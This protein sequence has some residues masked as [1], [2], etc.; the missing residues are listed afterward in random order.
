MEFIP[1]PVGSNIGVNIEEFKGILNYQGAEQ[2]L[3]S[4]LPP[5]CLPQGT[6][7]FTGRVPELKRL[8]EL[9]LQAGQQRT[10]AIVGVTGQGGIGKSALAFHFAE[11]YKASF[12]D[13]I[14]GERVNG[15]D[16]DTIVRTFARLADVEIPDD[17]ARPGAAVLMRK[18]FAHR[19]MLLI[20]DNAERTADIRNLHPGGKCAVIITTR[21]RSLPGWADVPDEQCIDLPFLSD[22]EAKD[23]LASF[24]GHASLDAE[25]EAVTRILELVGN[26]PLALEIVGKSLQHWRRR[27]PSFRLAEYAENLNL[28][29]L[30]AR[31]DDP[32]L[33]VRICFEQSIKL[34]SEYGQTAFARLSA[35]AQGGFA[36]RTAMAAMGITDEFAAEEQLFQLVDLSLLNQVQT[37][38]SRFIFH[39]LL[40][41]FAGELAKERGELDS[42]RERHAAH[43]A[44]LLAQETGDKLAADL[45]DLVRAAEWTAERGQGNWASFSFK[46]KLVFDRLGRWEEGERT[47]ALFLRRAEQ[48]RDAE[49]AAQLYLQ[50]AKFRL[51]KGDL[52]QA[53]ACLRAAD[54]LIQTVEPQETREHLNAM[55]L[56][57]LGGVYQRL[58]RFEEA[59]AAFTKSAEIEEKSGSERGQAMILNS[60]GGVF[61]RLGR[62]EE[63]VAAFTKSA[64]IGEKLNDHR[65]LAMVLNSLG[66]VFQRL[67]RFEEAV[68]AFT[69]SAEIGE[70]LG[71]QRHLAMVLNSLGGVYQRL[72]RF[73]EAV[74]AFTKSLEIREAQNDQQGLAMVLN[75]L[76][77]VYQ[78]LGRFE[79][80]VA[81][82]TKSAEIGETLHDQRHLAMV[83][84]S[85]GGVY[86]RL[87]RFEEAVAAFTKSAEIGK[88]LHDQ[89]HLAMVLNSL[90]G[91]YQ[92]LG[93]F[94]EAVAAFTKSAE[95]G[96]TLGDQRHLAMVLNSLGGVFQRLGQFDKAVA[97]FTKSYELAFFFDDKRGQAMISFS[98]GRA[99]LE[100]NQPEQAVLL[101]E[102][103]F[104]FD[105][106][107]KDRVGLAIVTPLLCQALR[108][109]GR[110]GEAADRC[111]RALAAAPGDRKLLALEES[112]RQPQLTG[113]VKFI[114]PAKDGGHSFGYIT[115]DDGGEDVRFDS[116]YVD[117]SGLSKGTRVA[118]E[119]TADRWGNRLARQVT[120]IGAAAK[121]A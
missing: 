69:K 63:A 44:R 102:R 11:Q 4:K 38:K 86:Q 46:M 24:I 3:P 21:D 80:A 17:E 25:P 113:T 74:A 54:A 15:K 57:S 6:P 39:P 42:A 14:I 90:G 78:R 109:V 89:R 107:M 87:G 76:G 99:L 43:F 121:E 110:T 101:L 5:F 112:L 62:F 27:K 114:S 98:W 115:M 45:D 51:L 120:V 56:N 73:E 83:L 28:E 97:A 29:R 88:T 34:L 119:I 19:R 67:G 68:A 84:N 35:C 105:E 77:G 75:S 60:L 70:T 40:H 41:E 100:Q 9:L 8:A 104:H 30:S 116:R 94:E 26:L 18:L 71:D 106:K 61:Q 16:A 64:E 12:P 92:R 48:E 1:L 79:E 49:T 50:Q 59:V 7:R 117:I 47:A 10:A 82:F 111:A 118:A 103:S 65:H 108:Q 32:N 93:R 66:G 36:L 23:L 55:R 81:A 33:N 72:G 91:V 53:E 31:P 95:I 13:G 58:G 85:L 52:A 20:F 37:D 22:Q 96:E 2:K